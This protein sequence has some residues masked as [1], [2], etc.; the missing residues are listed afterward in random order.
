MEVQVARYV[1]LYV[2]ARRLSY[3][4][5]ESVV[6]FRLYECMMYVY[7]RRYHSVCMYVYIYI[8][9]YIY[10]YPTLYTYNVPNMNVCVQA[11]ICTCDECMYESMKH[12]HTKYIY[13]HTR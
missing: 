10:M 7:A 8:Y 3:T 1:Y 13:I 6:H 12:T 11:H 9:I 2:C 5:I 4:S